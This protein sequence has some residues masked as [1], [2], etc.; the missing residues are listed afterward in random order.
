LAFINLCK[1]IY[2]S[3]YL[4]PSQKFKNFWLKKNHIQISHS[5]G[6]IIWDEFLDYYDV[7]TP[8]VVPRKLSFQGRA[9]DYFHKAGR[10]MAR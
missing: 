5:T 7:R 8:Q 9:D 6:S 4:K 3:N 2:P 1:K 10:R